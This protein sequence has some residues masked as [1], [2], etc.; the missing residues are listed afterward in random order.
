ML[1]KSR[2]AAIRTQIQAFKDFA[3]AARAIIP[4]IKS[5]DG[6]VCNKRL[7]TALQNTD[8]PGCDFWFSTSHKSYQYEIQ[9]YTRK[10]DYKNEP[11]S[12]GYCSTG[13]ISYDHFTCALEPEKAFTI[14]DNGNYRI[15]ADAIINKLNE[16][17]NYQESQAAA[18]EKG[19]SD[20]EIMREELQ[21]IADRLR[22][23]NSKYDSIARSMLGM[24]YSLDYRGNS[25]Y[26]DYSIKTC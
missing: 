10:R 11:D 25:S 26:K 5:F 13:Y 21:D 17:A 12:N 14:D 7:E 22:A 4:V 16:V 6:K 8:I 9:G 3:T 23:F 18:L 24:S 1:E 2:A 15:N 19:L 20:Y